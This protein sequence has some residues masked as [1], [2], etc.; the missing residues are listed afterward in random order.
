MRKL[1]TQLSLTIMMTVLFTIAIISLLSNVIINKEFEIYK[2]EQQKKKA[3]NI[4]ANFNNQYNSLTKEWNTE[5]IHGMGMYALYDGY[6]IKLY[7]DNG[8]IVWDAQNHDMAM[9]TEIMH[10][11]SER[12]EARRPGISGEFISHDYDLTMNGQKIGSMVISYYGPYFLNESDFRFL[13]TLNIVL[14]IIGVISLF[15]SLIIGGLL[16]VRITRP[17]KKTVYIAKRISEG[18]YSIRFEGKTKFEELDELAVAI[19][20]LTDGLSKQENLRKRLTVDIAHELRTPLTTLASHLEAMI[21][22]VWEPSVDRLQSCYEEIGRLSGL[23]AD[24]ERLAKTESDNLVLNKSNVDLMDIAHSCYDRYEIEAKKKNI[25]LVIEG[26]SSIVKAD[27]DRIS[28]V[29]AN[30]LTNAIKYTPENGHIRIEVKDT[31]NSSIFMIGDDGIGIPKHE[32]SLIFERFYRTD[33]SRNRKTGGAGIGLAIVKS[34]VTAHGGTV[35]AESNAE[36]GSVFTVTLPKK[37]E[38]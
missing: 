23:V 34:I 5:Y 18:N 19:N 3:D 29:M 32:L 9:C 11:I 27:K 4:V 28:Q 1:R 17:I 38:D 25:S 35:Q 33:K 12:M 31:K 14:I 8:K 22:G 21:E 13:D 7:D 26:S 2:A 30:L 36:Q 16:A 15:L 20:C 24:L 10:E 37:E 6:I